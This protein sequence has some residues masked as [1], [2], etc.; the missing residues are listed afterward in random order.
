MAKNVNALVNGFKNRDFT[1]LNGYMVKNQKLSGSFFKRVV[2]LS[3]VQEEINVKCSN[4]LE[5][6]KIM[7][8]YGGMLN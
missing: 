1:D 2:Q 4:P 8:K 7:N 6:Q 3:K 5:L